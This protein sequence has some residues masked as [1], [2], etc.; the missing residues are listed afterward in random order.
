MSVF[1][2]NYK[3]YL[4][5]SIASSEIEAAIVSPKRKAPYPISLTFTFT[6]EFYQICKEE[7]MYTHNVQL[8]SHKENESL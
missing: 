3:N 5:S 4:N 6:S 7:L 8:F 2:Q 1:D